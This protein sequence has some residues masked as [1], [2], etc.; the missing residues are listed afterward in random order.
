[1]KTT[2]RIIL[3]LLILRPCGF[4]QT[5]QIRNENELSTSPLNFT[6]A[7][8]DLT[9]STLIDVL[10]K[11][12]LEP[13]AGLHLGVEEV[14]QEKFPE[15]PDRSVRFS[16]SLENATVRDIVGALCQFDSRYTWYTDGLSINVFPREIIG[17]SSYLLN[18]GLEEITLSKIT[19]PYE[20][21]TP[22]AKLLPGEQLGYAGIGGGSSYSEPWSRVFR[23][24]TV[25]QLM[26]RISE[27]LG[28][29]GSWIM[30]GSKD[31]RFFF[32]FPVWLSSITSAKEQRQVL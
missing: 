30:S 3:L 14:L 25:R 11:L 24:L 15:A 10:S 18:R 16:L 2:M 12:S 22:L 32:F 1:M 8:F 13:L 7:H 26:D 19:D 27:H 5:T 28:P 20:A 4:G 6:V 17:N 21:L 9:D 29:R 31:Q 23:Q